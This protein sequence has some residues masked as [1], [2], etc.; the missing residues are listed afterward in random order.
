MAAQQAH[1]ADNHV[2]I[3]SSSVAFRPPPL[4][5]ECKLLVREPQGQRSINRAQMAMIGLQR[6]R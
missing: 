2:P 1:A 5:E 4:L 6:Q 3:Q